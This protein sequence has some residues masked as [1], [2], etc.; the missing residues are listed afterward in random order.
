[1]IEVTLELGAELLVLAKR[2]TTLTAGRARLEQAINSG[3][4]Y[5]KFCDMV[6]AQGGNLDAPRP[7]APAQ[8]VNCT[9]DGYVAAI[10][11]ERLGHVIIELGG[12]RRR[13][14]DQLDHSVGLEMLV[15][16][17][18]EV[19]RREPLM[20]VF[21][22]PQAADRVRGDV[23]AAIEIAENRADPPPLIVERI[24]DS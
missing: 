1:L 16:L 20:R 19:E 4:G 6:A 13:L 12:G 3:T 22:K 15:R 8:D 5:E 14:G 7:V 24:A 11:T 2:E 23:L 10:D 18:D 9:R 21:A 17:G